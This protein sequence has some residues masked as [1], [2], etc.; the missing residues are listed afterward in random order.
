M[1]FFNPSTRSSGRK[2]GILGICLTHGRLGEEMVRTAE[3]I[4]G[5]QEN[6]MGLSGDGY[7]PSELYRKL[8]EIV[9]SNDC[10]GVLI[11]VCLKG[12][13]CWNVACRVSYEREHVHV[14][15]GLNL[16]MLLS[17]LTKRGRY[18]MRDLVRIIQLDG[19]KSISMFEKNK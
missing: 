6:L 15:S 7:S 10:E 4:I 14:L 11:M 19:L 5:K 3:R 9:D 8:A 12:G 2:S 1:L 18:A 17:F 16:G 13:N